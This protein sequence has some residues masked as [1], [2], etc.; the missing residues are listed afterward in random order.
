VNSYAV[1]AYMHA[2]SIERK[3]H[4]L[5]LY[6]QARAECKP[7]YLNELRRSRNQAWNKGW[8]R[9][10]DTSQKTFLRVIFKL[11]FDKKKLAGFLIKKIIKKYK[12]FFSI[13]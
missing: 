1:F 4:V 9:E 11:G 5:G 13:I 7:P 8:E 2:N 10:K 12:K 3:F 6:L